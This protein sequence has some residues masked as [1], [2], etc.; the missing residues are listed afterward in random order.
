MIKTWIIEQ[1]GQMYLL[2]VQKIGKNVCGCEQYNFK[3][4]NQNGV[5][6]SDYIISCKTSEDYYQ[7]LE[8][9]HMIKSVELGV[10]KG[11]C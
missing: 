6:L 5:I 3:V 2:E 9:Y 7:E 11:G 4:V 1:N 8:N 10:K